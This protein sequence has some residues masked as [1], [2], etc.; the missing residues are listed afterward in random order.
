MGGALVANLH[1]FGRAVVLSG[2]N[3]WL[4]YESYARD[5][6][7]NGPLMTE[8]RAL[9]QGLPFYYQPGYIYAVAL[10]HLVL[11]ESLSAPL[12]MNA[13]LGVLT[14]LGLYALT[15]QL[16]GRVAA[17]VALLLFEVYRQTVFAQT[18]SLLLSENLLFPLVPPVLLLLARVARTG[19][20]TTL[21]AAGVALGLAGLART[22]PLALLPPA[23]LALLVGWRWL[24]LGWR[25]NLGRL[26]LLVLV[27][28][29]TVSLATM[30]N[31]LVSGR[32]VPIT[33]SAG[34][35]LWET[36]RPSSKVDLSRIDRDPLYERLGLD[37]TTREVLEFARQDPAGYV[38]TLV[39]MFL[40]AVGVQGAPSGSWDVQPLLLVMCLAYLFVSLLWRPARALPTWFLHA[41]VWSHLA[42]MTV[43]L[44]NQYGFRLILPM[45]V[46]MVPIVAGGLAWVGVRAVRLLAPIWTRAQAGAASPT[47]RSITPAARVLVVA[48]AALMGAAGLGAGEWRSQDLAR[49]AFY[50]LNGDAGIAARQ[51]ARDEL[52][53]QADVAYFVGDDSRS[54]D[55][56]YMSGLAYPTLRWFDG[57]RGLVLPRTDEQALYVVPDRAAADFAK[58]CL[59]EGASIGR[60][61]DPRQGAGLELFLASAGAGECAAP[62]ETIGAPFAEAADPVAR[63]IGLDGPA[64]IEPGRPMDVLI[65][66]ETLGRPR[67]RARPFVRL[68]DGQGRRWGTAETTVYPSSSWRP[69]E[70]AVG[71]AR[72]DVDPTL[73]P[74]Q[75]RLLG[76]FSTGG[77]TP[78]SAASAS[79]SAA[80]S[81]GAAAGA[82]QARLVADG[83][84]GSVGL[85]QALGPS[86]RLVSRST[87]LTLES[88]PLDRRL[89]ASLGAAKLIGVD[90]DRD[91]LPAGQRLRMGLFWQSAGHRPDSEQLSLIVRRPSGETLQEWRHA[92]VDDTYPIAQWKPGEIVRDTWDVVMPASLPPGEVELA[93]GI[94]GRA[95][96]PVDYVALGRVT[97]QDG[98]RQLTEPELRARL[99]A[100]FLSGEHLVGVDYKSRR[101]K[102]G[103]LVDMTLVWQQGGTQVPGDHVLSVALLDEAGRIL[104]QQEG[105]P[106][107]GKRPTSGWTA[108][109]Y[110]EDGWKFRLP[111]DLPR[112]RVRL[113]VSVVEP[114]S[115]QRQMT[116]DGRAWV[117]LPIEVGE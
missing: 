47:A 87:P 85:G 3:D 33:S 92:P 114:L 4:A 28:A 79:T 34:A 57:A 45:Y 30:R 83:A 100:D 96:Q 65:H 66:W 68:V 116:A 43:F 25:A 80:G 58:R 117:E 13:V 26:A 53:R 63:L 19:R 106:A 89:D 99:D 11:G 17:V 8:G 44:S 21:V 78:G 76:G 111:R 7:V 59:G 10:S 16:F 62:R 69:G 93:V 70:H 94:P 115:N 56:A 90:F 112:G 18:S 86:V 14:A 49:E 27:C 15:R 12:F 77:S 51:A 20:L 108:D 22:T 81:S 98:D 64:S 52:L 23:L 55:V 37:R 31:Y 29:L 41:F 1:L 24:G 2:G 48:V 110:V 42:Q 97:V 105:E 9:G 101:F 95:S 72:L 75:Y 36:H 102:P 109:E 61:T 38:G 71:L 39:P 107:G 113:A 67:N 82:G 32:V 103:D 46:A 88:L 91:S 74:G 60:E 40:F 5:V 50:G 104:A 6:L 54:T 73:P 35:N 84:W